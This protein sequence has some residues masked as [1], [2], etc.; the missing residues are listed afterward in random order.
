VGEV[1]ER[2]AD[3]RIVAATNRNLDD[4][5]RARTFRE[6]L[7]YRLRTFEMEIPPLRT[8]PE[9]VTPLVHHFLQRESDRL[10]NELWMT[11]DTWALLKRYAWP[12]NVRELESALVC[13]AAQAGRDGCI[14]AEFLPRAVRGSVD[15][16]AASPMDLA[17]HL[18]T[19]ERRLILKALARTKRSRTEAARALGISRNT[20]YDK[21]KRLGIDE[22]E[23]PSD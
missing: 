12:G 6:D 15:A 7:L 23:V 4:Q 17:Q 18:L 20:L 21:M 16:P 14:H 3:L 22:K 11:G 5:V 1:Q 10:H 13:A 2:H 19:E 9:D 8:R